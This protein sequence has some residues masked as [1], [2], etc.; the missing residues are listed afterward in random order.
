MKKFKEEDKYP[1]WDEVAQ[2]TAYI[3]IM[4]FAGLIFATCLLVWMSYIYGEY[5]I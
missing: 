5:L 3:V 2:V 4:C 1:T